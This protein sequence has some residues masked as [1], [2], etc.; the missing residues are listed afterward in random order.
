MRRFVVLAALLLTSLSSF[1]TR[2]PTKRISQFHVGGPAARN[3]AKSAKT[4]AHRP[5]SPWLKPDVNGRAMAPPAGKRPVK[6][7]SG[8]ASSSSVSFVTATQIP[9]T[10]IDDDNTEPVMGDFNGDGKEDVAKI[11]YNVISSVTTYQISTLLGNGDGT[12]HAAVL[13]NT[14][15][16]ADDP[17]VVGDLNGDGKEDII[18]VHPA[19]NNGCDRA[20]R[21]KAR[22]QDVTCGASMDVLISNGDGTFAAPVN[23]TI[24]NISFLSGGVLTDVNG[25]GKLDV[26]VVDD[27]TPANVIVLLGNG[28]GTFQ[29]ASTMSQLTTSAPAGMFFADF[30][31]DGNIDFAGEIEG[32]QVQVTL[33][34]G[35]A[36]Y[37]A[38]VSLNTPD[39][40]Y[41]SCF[42]TAGDLNGDGKPEIVSVNCG[43]DTITIYVNSGTGTFATGVYHNSSGGQYTSPYSAAI[44]DLNGD[45]NADILVDNED[46]GTLSVFLGNGDGTV[47]VV[48]LRYATGGDPWTPP[49]LADFN[50]DGLL[51]VMIA[52][53]YYSF[54]YL[55]GYGDGSFRSALVYDLP[56]M[57][58]QTIFTFSV[59]SADFNG[60][61]IP[62]VVAGQE[63]NFG[64]TGV[65]VYLGKGDGTFYPGVSYG[66][67]GT[68]QN[69]AVAD[70]NGDGKPDIA[71]TDPENG[72]VQILLGNG[73]GTFSVG[74]AYSTD[75]ASGPFPENIVT[76]D[77]NHDGNVDLAIAN[78]GSG[79]IGVL[80]GNGDGTFQAVTPYAVSGWAPYF[81]ATADLNGDGYLDLEACATTDGSAAVVIMLANADNSGTFTAPAFVNT[82]GYPQTVAFG[83]LNGDGKLDMAVTE[84]Q[85]T[86]FGDISIALGN[87]DGTFGSFTDYAASA[88]A[89]GTGDTYPASLQMTDM[90]GDGKLDLV[91][92]NSDYGTLAVALGNG[93]GTIGTPVEFP[94][95]EYTWGLALADV[96]NDGAMDVLIGEDES[97]GFNVLL[98]GNGTGT[99]GNYTFG[100]QTPSQTVTAGGST[101]YTLNL[102]GLNGYNG[103]ITFS[104]GTLPTGA[105][106]SFSPTSVV[107]NG[108][109]PLTTTM[110]ITTTAAGT[111]TTASALRHVGPG[112]QPGSPILMASFG[113]LGLFGLLIAGSG[114]AGRRRRAAIVLGV[115]VLVTLGM[116]VACDNDSAKT[117]TTTTT[118]TTGTPA[119]SYAVTVTSTGTGTT[120]PTHTLNVTL[121][122]QA[123]AQ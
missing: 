24:S 114:A 46:D 116:L 97:G 83:D 94:T 79:T 38:P 72:V 11:V 2:T 121:I 19:V 77:F 84:Y 58:D 111:T 101:T 25:D 95:S 68:L 105:A 49:L 62:D 53:D 117:T 66:P 21:L 113:G 35:A 6:R 50:G 20:A 33:A 120:A 106:C 122:V 103:T 86:Y 93:D 7:A 9:T 118:T 69:V 112:A 3:S 27:D 8:L 12:F 40:A 99:A 65:A 102:A 37:G 85:G 32:G 100:T 98:N 67:S 36:T 75:T 81:V 110:T 96:N 92:I 57:F 14:P 16:N 60:D 59:A 42:N 30:N 107:A 44:G 76:G 1:A 90:N 88:S 82:V 70:F 80:L 104:C 115:L 39:G 29:A 119:G 63:H 51:D 109:L 64:S 73:D 34:T 48:P 78:P 61:G 28:D 74:L 23:Y 89:G 52:D 108:G 26:L 10:G 56:N 43:N 5:V 71:A 31:G 17:I 45:G 22:P 123:A 87:G 54:A 55:Q 91:Y 47:N 41:N 15:G 13:T 18:Q 4:A